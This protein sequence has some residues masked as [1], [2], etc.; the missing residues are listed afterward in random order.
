MNIDL[1][2]ISSLASIWLLIL[3]MRTNVSLAIMGLCAGYVFS[4]LL[5]DELVSLVVKNTSGLQVVPIVSVVSITLILVPALLILFRF[6]T[7]QSGRFLQHLIPAFGFALLATLLIYANL[8]LE[9]ERYLRDTSIL[10]Q[11][12][13]QLELLIAAAVVGIAVVD[14]IVHDGEHRRRYKRRHKS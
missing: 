10:F 7:H 14:V 8:P 5:S 13:E 6:R 1:I 3:V 2:A 4:D 12:L 11:Q 9:A